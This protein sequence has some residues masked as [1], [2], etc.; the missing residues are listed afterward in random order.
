MP[1]EFPPRKRTPATAGHSLADN[2][3]AAYFEESLT[4]ESSR[5]FDRER[6]ESAIENKHKECF[7]R[8]RVSGEQAT[9]VDPTFPKNIIP[10]LEASRE[11]DPR[12]YIMDILPI[13][14][15]GIKQTAKNGN[16]ELDVVVLARPVRRHMHRVARKRRANAPHVHSFEDSRGSKN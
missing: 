6:R 13:R 2:L 12:V 11:A 4:S 9:H 1:T 8:L 14:A 10:A 5:I 16:P 3:Q 7:V 15:F